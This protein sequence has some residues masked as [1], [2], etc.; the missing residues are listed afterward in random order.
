MK[1]NTRLA[2]NILHNGGI[3]SLPTDTVQGLSC[4]PFSNALQR[5][6]E[7]KR[8]ACHKG[9]ILISNDRKQFEAF[10]ENPQL[11]AKIQVGTEPTTYLLKAALNI[12]PLLQG[13]MD[14]IAIRLTNNPLIAD[15]CGSTNSAL[16]STS[17]NISGLP[18]AQTNLKLRVYFNNQ[19]DFIISPNT[20]K[21]TPSHIV[22][23]T[24]GE[25]IR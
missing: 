21:K 10:V 16:V 24:T 11:L 25:K 7:L 13:N 8:R 1:V 18:V 19:L 22:N 9:L 17:A 14:T 15:L 5:L 6:I 4:L 2:A 3:V 23:L 20:R 12:P